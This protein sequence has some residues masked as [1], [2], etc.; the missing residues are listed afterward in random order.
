MKKQILIVDDSR[1]SQAINQ[2]CLNI[3]GQERYELEF[4]FC[5]NG[6]EA[7]N[8]LKT[9]PIDLIISDLRMPVM[10]GLELTR[11]I[12]DIPLISEIPV[13]VASSILD[14]AKMKELEEN[15]VSYIVKKPVSAEK[16]KQALDAIEF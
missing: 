13:I 16:F 11:T 14:D 6:Q 12:R 9:K 8:F 2:H 3:A 15:K 10:D 4:H 1:T 5:L 7:L